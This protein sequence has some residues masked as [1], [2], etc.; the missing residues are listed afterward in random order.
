MLQISTLQEIMVYLTQKIDQKLVILT[1]GQF[2]YLLKMDK[3]EHVQ[4]D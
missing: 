1:F 4:L 3:F 2:D